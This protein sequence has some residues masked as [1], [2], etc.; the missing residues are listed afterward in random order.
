[1]VTAAKQLKTKSEVYDE[2]FS[3]FNEH[4]EAV[5]V[6]DKRL[7]EHRGKTQ[8]GSFYL[9]FF[10][11]KFKLAKPLVYR[12]LADGYGAKNDRS[13]DWIF[14]ALNDA[15]QFRNSE[16]YSN[17]DDDDRRKWQPLPR[18][19]NGGEAS[20][21]RNKKSIVSP[22]GEQLSIASVVSGYCTRSSNP[23]YMN[24]EWEMVAAKVTSTSA[25]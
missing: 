19:S 12:E 3:Y 15:I 17:M 9:V 11:T 8:R 16:Q 20:N 5:R 24:E 10:A 25:K 6:G 2:V 22:K 14:E 13:T 21:L 1:M 23:R 7:S 4:Y 18:L